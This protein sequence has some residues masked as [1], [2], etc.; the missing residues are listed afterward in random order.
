MYKANVDSKSV[1]FNNKHMYMLKLSKSSLISK[2]KANIS[3]Q[4][5]KKVNPS[6][7]PYY[8]MKEIYQVSSNRQNII[9]KNINIIRNISFWTNI[10]CETVIEQF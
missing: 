4:L 7:L 6:R 9:Y 5:S 2:D 8:V 3:I 1:R 10:E